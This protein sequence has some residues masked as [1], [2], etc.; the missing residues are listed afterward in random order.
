M[1][2]WRQIGVVMKGKSEADVLKRCHYLN[3]SLNRLCW[4]LLYEQT[5][6]EMWK[7]QRDLN[8]L[9]RRIIPQ[10]LIFCLWRIC[11]GFVISERHLHPQM[12]IWAS[13]TVERAWRIQPNVNRWNFPFTPT[14]VS[15]RDEGGFHISVRRRETE[16]RGNDKQAAGKAIRTGA[17]W[18]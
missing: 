5:L 6:V 14:V 8:K 4:T 16:R 10:P 2:V 7:F 18:K 9:H 11:F 13:M 1:N 15:P 12:I 17:H 3:L